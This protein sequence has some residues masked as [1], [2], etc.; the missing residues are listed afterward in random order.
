MADHKELSVKIDGFNEPFIIGGLWNVVD[1]IEKKKSLFSI[2]K[3]DNQNLHGGSYQSACVL[4]TSDANDYRAY[5]LFMDAPKKAKSLAQCIAMAA[6]ATGRANNVQISFFTLR[7]DK[8][9]ETIWNVVV[10]D[11]IVQVDGD[12]LISPDDS[13]DVEDR[14]KEEFRDLDPIVERFTASES[15]GEIHERLAALNRSDIKSAQ[16][17]SFAGQKKKIIFYA[18][19]LLL[20][21]VAGFFAYEWWEKVSEEARLAEEKARME[22]EAGRRIE[23]LKKSEFPPVW[24]NEPMPAAVISAVERNVVKAPL[25]VNGWS[26]TGFNYSKGKLS[27][28]YA[29]NPQDPWLPP[30]GKLN[31]KGTASLVTWTANLPKGER[32]PGIM[33]KAAAESWLAKLSLGHPWKTAWK[34]NGRMSKTVT[35]GNTPVTVTAAYQTCNI[36]LSDLR[37][38]GGA[39]LLLNAPGMVIETVTLDMKGTWTIKGVLYVLP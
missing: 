6:T 18:C 27:A 28:A 35:I 13:W 37:S 33:K 39:A 38:L 14:L 2:A 12:K 4:N 20:V 31:S 8:G 7:D 36:T 34:F 29:R 24:L 25:S 10:Q 19:V 16:I 32:H 23:N 11:G 22:A 17:H 9:Q 30:P 26:L 15:M 21:S 1:K 3:I 5:A